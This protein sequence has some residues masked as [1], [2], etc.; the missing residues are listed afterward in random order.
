MNKNDFLFAVIKRDGHSIE[1][2]NMASVNDFH[3]IY[4]NQTILRKNKSNIP[5]L[6]WLSFLHHLSL[7]HF[8][9]ATLTS[10]CQT[11]AFYPM[12]RI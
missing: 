3:E 5:L 10:N 6:L 2:K 7:S 1:Y 4:K 9:S 12:R 11:S 8:V